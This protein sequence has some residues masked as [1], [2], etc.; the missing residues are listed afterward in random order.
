M[1]QRK[2]RRV[3]PIRLLTVLVAELLVILVLLTI[4][5]KVFPDNP[6]LAPLLHSE[7]KADVVLDPGHGGY[8]AGSV[9]QDLYEKDITL[10]LA[11]DIGN[12]LEANGYHVLYTRDSDDVPWPDSEL[13]DLSERVDI[14]N[15]SGAKLFVS[16]HTNALEE[17]SSVYGYEIWGK[18]KEEKVFTLSKNILD[19]LQTLS[20]SQNRGMKDQDLMPLQVL[21]NNKLPSVLIEIG[22]LANDHDRS[23]LQDPI[24][25]KQIAD[26]IADGIL[27]TLKDQETAEKAK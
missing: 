25:R 22:F 23:H 12:R 26:K 9:Y 4:C 24:K 21:Q 5:V 8:D 18:I 13:E 20:Y 2:K 6:I 27:K 10:A 7:P 3:N 16:L 14:S 15:H 11:K 17:D 19:S 1:K